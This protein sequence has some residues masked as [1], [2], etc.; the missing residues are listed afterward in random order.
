MDEQCA[1]MSPMSVTQDVSKLEISRDSREEHRPNM[2]LISVTFAVSKPERSRVSRL[3]QPSNIW[4]ISVAWKVFKPERSAAFSAEKL[5]NQLSNE[6]G[7]TSDFAL[8]QVVYG[9]NSPLDHDPQLH[10]PFPHT[11]ITWSSLGFG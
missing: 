11:R 4:R 9:E 7:A 8:T 2:L 1:N 5:E 3:E 10:L 6:C